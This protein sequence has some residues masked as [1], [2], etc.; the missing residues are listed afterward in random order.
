MWPSALRIRGGIRGY[1][2]ETFTGPTPFAE[3]GAGRPLYST[4]FLMSRSFQVPRSFQLM[5]QYDWRRCR[6]RPS[7]NPTEGREV[8]APIASR[9]GAQANTATQVIAL[10]IPCTN[11]GASTL[12]VWQRSHW[13]NVPAAK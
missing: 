2:H 7:A 10:P 5:V 4:S 9:P 8:V 1:C 6:L 3:D 11:A 12:R 13:K